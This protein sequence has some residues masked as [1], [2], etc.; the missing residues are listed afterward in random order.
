MNSQQIVQNIRDVLGLL[1][2]IVVIPAVWVM[3]G[4]K[5]IDLPGEVIGA[6]IM[7]WTLILEYYFQRKA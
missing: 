3:Q 4:F 7:G 2:L 6:T 1:T 5:V